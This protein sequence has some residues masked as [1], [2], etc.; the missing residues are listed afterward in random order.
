[1]G[2]I[3]RLTDEETTVRK[4]GRGGDINEGKPEVRSPRQ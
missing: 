2:R 3:S 4:K 1:M